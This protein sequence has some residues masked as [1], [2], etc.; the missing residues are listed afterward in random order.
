MVKISL[1]GAG[2]IG[3]F[4]A[5]S[6]HGQRRKDRIQT[7]FSMEENLLR[8]FAKRHEIPRYTTNMDEAI[9]DPETDLVIVALPNFLHKEAILKACE[10]KETCAVHQTPCPECR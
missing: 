10:G 8:E 3:D 9:A 1:L 5:M 7:V 6:L 4:Y 2:F